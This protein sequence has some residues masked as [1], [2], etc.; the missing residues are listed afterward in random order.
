VRSVAGRPIPINRIRGKLMPLA[1]GGR[2]LATIHPSAIL[3]APEDEARH[4]MFKS[5][6]ADLKACALALAKAA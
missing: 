2:M 5:F 6:V 4:T 1:D 3:R